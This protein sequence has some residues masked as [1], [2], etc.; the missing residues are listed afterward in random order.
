MEEIWIACAIVVCVFIVVGILGSL[1]IFINILWE[2]IN[3]LP[4]NKLKENWEVIERGILVILIVSSIA[5]IVLFVNKEWKHINSSEREYIKVINLE[6]S[7]IKPS[8]DKID[9][10][11]YYMSLSGDKEFM[12]QSIQDFYTVPT[13]EEYVLKLVRKDDNTAYFNLVRVKKI[14]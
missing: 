11:N 13:G 7:V 2:N 12:T 5:S 10:K 14:K 3:I 1:V 4:K 6:N 8:I 9:R